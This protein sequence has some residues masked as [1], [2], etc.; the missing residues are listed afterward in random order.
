MD[1]LCTKGANYRMILCSNPYAQYLARKPELD[2]A[3]HRVL[4]KGWYILG[5]EVKTFEYEFADYIGSSHGIGVGSGTEAIHLALA[6]CDIGHGD[7]VIT[8]SHT[9]VA[10]VAA[11]ELTGAIPVFVDIEPHYYTLDPAKLEKM[12]TPR[13]KAVIPV[14]LYGQPADLSPILA[15]AQ[16]HGLRVIEDCAQAT[17]ATYRDKRVG[18]FGDMACFSFYPTKNL[19]ALGD[20]GM[21]VTTDDELA[22][23]ARLLRE[24]GWAERYISHVRG[25]NS[26]LDELQAAILRVKLSYLDAD[27][28]KRMEIAKL[29]NENLRGTNIG[30]P[31]R[32]QD[33]G[34]VYH[35]YV[36]RSRDRN[37][38]MTFLKSHNIGA[39]IHYPVPVHLQPAYRC[40]LRGM[41]DLSVTEAVANEIFSLPIYPELNKVDV[42]FIIEKIKKYSRGIK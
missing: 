6:A 5:K 10:T 23:K 9:A 16:R 36:V 12:I 35:I 1:S 39:L 29:Y 19:G 7:E 3:I 40:R 22:R 11:I 18:S 38:I 41:E 33:A 26:R 31:N 13:T 17:G 4:D 27:N 21:V 15:V 25:W 24:Y 8:V 20:G 42:E 28:T 32:R 37:G 34:H 14:H 2:E 30:I